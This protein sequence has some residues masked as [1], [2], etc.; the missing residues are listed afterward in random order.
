MVGQQ[1]ARW[2]ALFVITGEEDKVKERLLYKLNHGELKVLVPKRKLRERKSGVWNTKIRTLFPGYV[3]LNGQIGVPEY[4]VI[5]NVPGIIKLLRD[6]N[7][8]LE[9]SSQEISIIKRLIIDNETIGSSS[10]YLENKRVVV[11]DGPLLGLEGYIESVD[12][13]KGRAKVRLNLMGE[14]RLVELSV[15]MVQSAS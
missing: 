8:P 2:F 3:L 10:I 4:E 13:R 12:K 9:I 6:K 1:E 5:K 14:P 15:Q 7:S 11:I